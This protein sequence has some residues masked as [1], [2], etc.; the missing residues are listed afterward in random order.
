[1]AED[2]KDVV[3]PYPTREETV[4]YRLRMNNSQKQGESSVQ[5]GPGSSESRMERDP[6]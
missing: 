1:M 3:R 2:R 6:K 4:S 5:I